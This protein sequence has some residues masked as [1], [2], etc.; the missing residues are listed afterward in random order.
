ML[1]KRQSL[2]Y[3]LV[4]WMAMNVKKISK[5]MLTTTLLA[6]PHICYNSIPKKCLYQQYIRKKYIEATNLLFI[7]KFTYNLRDPLD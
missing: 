4:F 5:L 2:I 1:S 7:N 3:S 6:R